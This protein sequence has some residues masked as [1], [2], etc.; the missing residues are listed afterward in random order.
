MRSVLSGLLAAV[1][2]AGSVASVGLSQEGAI[3]WLSERRAS[4]L[5]IGRLEANIALLRMQQE[6]VPEWRDV[7][8]VV[9]RT[10]FDAAKQKFVAFQSG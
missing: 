9:T 8:W 10:E 1:V 5:D 7:D 4:L 3:R 6:G 2:L